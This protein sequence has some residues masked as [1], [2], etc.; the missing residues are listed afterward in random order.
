MHT[1]FKLSLFDL[2]HSIKD[3]ILKDSDVVGSVHGGHS[4]GNSGN[5]PPLLLPSKLVPGFEV[6]LTGAIIFRGTLTVTYSS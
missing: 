2:V 6:V 1:Y 4:R 5:S 3:L